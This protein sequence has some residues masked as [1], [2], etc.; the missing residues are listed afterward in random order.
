MSTP[1]TNQI[2]DY[3][4]TTGQKTAVVG[5]RVF[6][7]QKDKLAKEYEGNASALVRLLLDEYFS[8]RLPMAKIK[9]NQISK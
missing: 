6:A 8:G 4:R 3:N 5:I 9:F 7:T 2:F 1:P